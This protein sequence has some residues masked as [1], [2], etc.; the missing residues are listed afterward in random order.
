M[1]KPNHDLPKTKAQWLA[2]IEACHPKEIVLGLERVHKIGKMGRLL[3]FACPVVTVGGTNGKGSTLA[4]LATLLKKGGLRVGMYTSPH[5]TTFN[6][7]LQ[8]AGQ[9]CTDEAWCQAFAAID[10]LRQDQNLTF[11]EFVTLSALFILQRSAPDIVLLEVGLGGRLDAV[12]AVDANLVILTM[13][14][15][16]HQAWLGQT[17]EQIAKEKAGI[18]RKQIPVVLGKKT[19]MRTLAAAIKAQQNR[20]YKAGQDFDLIEDTW[21]WGSKVVTLPNHYLPSASL[22]LALAAYQLLSKRSVLPEVDQVV[23]ALRDKVMVGRYQPFFCQGRFIVVDVAHNLD[24]S[25]WLAQK[26][27]HFKKGRILGVWASM[28]D[29]VLTDIIAPIKAQVATWYVGQLSNV[30]RSANVAALAAALKKAGA[31]SVRTLGTIAQA[32]DQAL[33]EAAKDDWIVAFGSFYTVAAVLA[34]SQFK[35]ADLE[36]GLYRL[37]QAVRARLGD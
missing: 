22:C 3:T 23:L 11:F 20:A 2:H 27:A 34:A 12:N 25:K 26:L 4:I 31:K 9:C 1:K 30:G 13:V 35:A 17:L 7:R 6:E 33:H 28:Q 21:R 29:K 36:N 16:D 19:G 5:L 15:Y 32:F 10:M 14:G 24:G 18:L 8:I 37:D